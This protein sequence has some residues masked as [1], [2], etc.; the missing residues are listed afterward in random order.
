[1]QNHRQPSGLQS[2]RQFVTSTALLPLL[3]AF[4]RGAPVTAGSADAPRP[5]RLLFTSR[6]KT[7][8][9]NADGSGLRYFQFDKPG[10]A[11]WQPGAVFPDGRRVLFLSMER[12][13]RR[14]SKSFEHSE[15]D[16]VSRLC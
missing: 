8:L 5:N 1:M 12:M 6:G 2:R 11:T 9:V 16:L 7:A 10:Q 3:A 14:F 4:S 15:F 13:A